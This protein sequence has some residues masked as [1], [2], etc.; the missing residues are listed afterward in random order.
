ML[1]DNEI[2]LVR[3]QRCQHYVLCD[4]NQYRATENNRLNYSVVKSILSS[5]N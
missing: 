4:A 1:K 2:T 3:A 5:E